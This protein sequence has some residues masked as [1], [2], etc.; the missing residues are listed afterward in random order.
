[1]RRPSVSHS[2][3]RIKSSRNHPYAL[4]APSNSVSSI[5][6]TS[7]AH[8]HSSHFVTPSVHFSAPASYPSYPSY[9][10]LGLQASASSGD[11]ANSNVGHAQ[12]ESS[13]N[14]AMMPIWN[15]SNY[16]H[17][18]SSSIS[19]VSS[20]LSSSSH[21]SSGWSDISNSQDNSVAVM[22]PT[23]HAYGPN[24]NHS[25]SNQYYTPVSYNSS[26]ATQ[27]SDH[28]TY[29]QSNGGGTTSLACLDGGVSQ[30]H[31][32]DGLQQIQLRNLNISSQNTFPV[33]LQAQGSAYTT[34]IMPAQYTS[35]PID[36]LGHNAENM[37]DEGPSLNAVGFDSTSVGTHPR[38]HALA[39]AI[40]RSAGS[41]NTTE[42]ARV[43]FVR[44]W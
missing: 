19:S 42:K 7:R 41:T 44:G 20:D 28:H 17:S 16:I 38:L 4:R 22:A 36:G 1:M 12:G 2:T 26:P 39:T 6:S 29:E 11:L 35:S 13:T 5:S 14:A 27:F 40:R 33:A 21:T 18:R 25:M 37:S 30:H 31:R 43:N 10:N 23:H 3:R 32:N 34:S 9:P 15:N 24:A 8:S